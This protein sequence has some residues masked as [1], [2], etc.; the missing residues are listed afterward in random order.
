[1]RR[2]TYSTVV[3]VPEMRPGDGKDEG[4]QHD[5]ALG[6]ARY[7]A[8]CALCNSCLISSSDTVNTSNEIEYWLRVYVSMYLPKMEDAQI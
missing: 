7:C 8:G 4:P 5:G 3:K 2:S 6:N 1:M